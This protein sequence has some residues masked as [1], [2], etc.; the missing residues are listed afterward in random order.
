[1]YS[2][3]I[4]EQMLNVSRKLSREFMYVKVDFY[5][6]ENELKFSEMTFTLGSGI[7]RYNKD[8]TC[9]MDRELGDLIDISRVAV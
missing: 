7:Y 3:Y 9:E 5:I 2:M 6:V 4:L 1:M 8:W